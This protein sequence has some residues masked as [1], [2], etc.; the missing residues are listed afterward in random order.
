MRNAPLLLLV[1]ALTLTA[2]GCFYWLDADPRQLPVGAPAPDFEL[3]AAAGPPVGLAALRAEGH[4]VLVFYRG[5][6]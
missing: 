2:P 4:A 5:H 1:T 6:W 3:P